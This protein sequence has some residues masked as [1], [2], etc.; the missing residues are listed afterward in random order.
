M[1]PCRP[2]ALTRRSRLIVNKRQHDAALMRK[3]ICFKK[4]RLF[5]EPGGSFLQPG[6]VL[7]V[8]SILGTFA[9]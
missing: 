2:R 7:V 5:L 9:D 3:P 6:N 8:S 4:A 1:E